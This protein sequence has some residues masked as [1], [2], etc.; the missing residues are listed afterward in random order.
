MGGWGDASVVKALAEQTW[1]PELILGTYKNTSWVPLRLETK[2]PPNKLARKTSHIYE[3]WVRLRVL[4]S[5]KCEKQLK[6]I[7]SIN[8]RSPH[9]HI[10]ARALTHT[11]TL[12][13]KREDIAYSVCALPTVHCHPP[14]SSF[15]SHALP[16]PHSS[17]SN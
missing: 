3:L 11:H 10:C 15:S 9:A 5:L 6:V 14:T 2:V 1:G 4:A 17:A 13:G 16:P 8:L 7:P 12:N